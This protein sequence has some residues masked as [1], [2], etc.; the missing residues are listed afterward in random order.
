VFCQLET[1]RQCLPQSVRRTINELPES[2]DETYERVIAEIKR[3]NQVHAYRMLQCLAVATRPLSAIE[4]AELL[5]FDFDV[6]KGG[7][8]KLNSD[9]RWGDHEQAVL[10]T[11]SSLITIIPSDDSPVVQF[12]HF[13]VKEFLMSNR[14]AASTGDISQYHISLSDAHTVLAQA[15]LGVL[16]RDPDDNNNADNTPLAEYAAEHWVTHA[17][18]EDVASH[19]RDGM[20]CLFDP[21]K[22]YFEAWVGLH[23][24]DNHSFDASGSEPG[25]RPL[26]YA[27]L[28]GFREPVERILFKHPQCASAWGGFRGTALHSASYA[29]HL[30]IVRSLLRHNVGVDLR[31]SRNKTPLQFAAEVGH[32][33]I[34][35]CLLDRGADVNLEEDTH[36]SPLNWAAYYGHTE[37]VRMLLEHGAD[38]D[39]KD[40]GDWTPLRSAVT[41]A[42]SLVDRSH[43]VRSL[44]EHGANPNA[45]DSHR[46]TPLHVVS[47]GRQTLDVARI[48]IEYGADLNARDDKGKTPLQ[49]ALEY[50]QGET[51]RLLAEHLSGSGEQP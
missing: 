18:V 33:D 15:C 38:V 25:A 30:Q 44:L 21:N 6:A 50:G 29:G 5:A 11:C 34:V 14:L 26:Y 51:V 23:D 36:N 37:V 41:T 4:L 7:I 2:L 45:R 16:L 1:L 3:A 40:D 27:A 10:S 39:S 35:Q 19:V 28:C 20:E 47:M 17:Q 13:S 24:I 43:L 12:S 42:Y 9:W 49:V 8:P 31:G 22:P 32:L 48:L 46:R